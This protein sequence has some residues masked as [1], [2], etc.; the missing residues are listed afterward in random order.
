M[1]LT[2]IVCLSPLDTS[3]VSTFC[4]KELV[5]GVKRIP[6]SQCFFSAQF[7]YRVGETWSFWTI[8]IRRNWN[9]E[10]N[11]ECPFFFLLVY[12]AS[13]LYH[14]IPAELTFKSWYEPPMNVHC[15]DQ[16]EWITDSTTTGAGSEHLG[17]PHLTLAL[18][19]I[20]ID[21]EFPLSLALF[22]SSFYV[23]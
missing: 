15:L 3:L 19:Q 12:L 16:K 17:V 8:L 1:T 5:L 13:V 7:A 23:A 11:S 20:H 10:V 4:S 22:L 6:S 21:E 9:L 14:C 2:F 18:Y